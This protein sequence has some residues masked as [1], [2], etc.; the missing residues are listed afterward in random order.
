MHSEA[1]DAEVAAFV[2]RLYDGT[3]T[4]DDRKRQA[5]ALRAPGALANIVA[6]DG[7]P[8]DALVSRVDGD[9]LSWMRAPAATTSV[10][11][12]A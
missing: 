11:A 5:L 6:L 10:T 1:S 2:T 3:A 7:A 9:A 4:S 12:A 8:L